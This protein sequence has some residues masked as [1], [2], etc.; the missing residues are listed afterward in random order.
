M[1]EGKSTAIVAVEEGGVAAIDG[2]RG[3]EFG[4]AVAGGKGVSPDLG[5]A[6]RRRRDGRR[7]SFD[8][9]LACAMVDAEEATGFDGLGKNRRSDDA[10]G[11]EVVDAPAVVGAWIRVIGCVHKNWAMMM[12]PSGLKMVVDRRRG[13]RL[14]SATKKK[15]SSLHAAIVDDGLQ[16]R[17]IPGRLA[18]ADMMGGLDHPI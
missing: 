13:R 17:R 7:R 3:G 12:V 10:V 16:P 4:G 2:G 9:V 18:A 15:E 8:G 1:R 14:S 5:S 11:K 6:R